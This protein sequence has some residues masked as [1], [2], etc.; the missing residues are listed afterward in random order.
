MQTIFFSSANER[1]LEILFVFKADTEAADSNGLTPL[2]RAAAFSNFCYIKKILFI[3]YITST[4]VFPNSDKNDKVLEVLLKQKAKVNAADN[5]G[6]TALH[7]SAYS[8]NLMNKLRL[9]CQTNHF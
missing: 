4:F 9:L 6:W 7:Y 3:L 5:K 8:G 2:I 1:A